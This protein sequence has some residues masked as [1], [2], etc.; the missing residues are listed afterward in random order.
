MEAVLAMLNFPLRRVKEGLVELLVP[1]FDAYKRPDGVYEP[2]WAP[3]FYNPKMDF[4]RDIAVLFARA[5]AR[6]RGI[7]RI[8]VVEPLAGSGVRALRYA[9]EANAIVY[10]S[11]ISS[12]AIALIKENI[13][14]NNAENR[15]FVQ[16]ADANRYME[17]LAEERVKPHIVDLD[18]FGSPA[19]FL[20]A[21]LDL[22]GGRGVLAATA[23]DTAPLS[24]T[25]AKA[26]RR[27][28]DVVPARTAWEKEQAVRVLVGY[29]VRRAANREYAAKPLL[30]Y[31]ADHY[32][33]VY[34]EFERGARK[35]DKA[36]EMLAYAY[37]CPIC[38]YTDYY[39]HY[40]RRRCPYCNTPMIVVGPV[41]SGPLASEKIV[42]LMLEEL[43]KVNW[44]QNPK[45][46]YELLSLIMAEAPITKPYYRVDRLCSWLHLN[47]PKLSKIIEVLQSKGYR[48]TRTHFD[49]RG[50]KTDAPHSIVVDTVLRLALSST[51]Q[52]QIGFNRINYSSTS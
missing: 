22:L 12:D 2:A 44:L 20:E 21:A 41:Y 1:D 33:R 13:K 48:A 32:V 9:I 49:P 40:T 26:L 36:L 17:Q 18:P 7:D 14:L 23:T 42:T 8:V 10:A 47:M 39:K 45:R 16:R 28:Y 37:Y 38:Q 43:N 5:Y 19:P 34:V 35:A 11:D 25:H 51:P 27:R 52:N 6:L 3:V 31:Y 24:G 30:A 50:I 4:N 46:A 15:V 29:I